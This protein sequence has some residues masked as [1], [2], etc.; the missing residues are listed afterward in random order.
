MNEL[1]S[2]QKAARSFPR[3]IP[4]RWQVRHRRSGTGRRMH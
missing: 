2:Q 3:A 1:G 4:D